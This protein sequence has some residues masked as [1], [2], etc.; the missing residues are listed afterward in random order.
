MAVDRDV[1]RKA[2]GLDP[3]L[4]QDADERA[5]VNDAV[6][7]QQRDVPKQRAAEPHHARAN[8]DLASAELEEIVVFSHHVRVLTLRF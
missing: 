5:V 1:D 4:G 6:L 8:P 7:A 2:G 3:R